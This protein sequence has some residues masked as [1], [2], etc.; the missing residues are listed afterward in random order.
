MTVPRMYSVYNRRTDLPVV[1]HG[2]AAECAAVMGIKKNSFYRALMRQRSREGGPA[3][4]AKYEI[5][6]DDD[7]DELEED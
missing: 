7:P 5:V 3:V 1:I 2:A 6:V 4:A